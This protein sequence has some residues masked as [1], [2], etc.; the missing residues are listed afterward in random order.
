MCSNI[1]EV[2]HKQAATWPIAFHN[3]RWGWASLVQDPA[4][5]APGGKN[6]RPNCT[7]AFAPHDCLFDH[8]CLIFCFC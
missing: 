3:A 1:N 8:A 2:T 6:R 4:R 5:R 7:L